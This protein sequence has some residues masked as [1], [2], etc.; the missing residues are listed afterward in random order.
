LQSEELGP[1]DSDSECGDILHKTPSRPEMS[2]EAPIPVHVGS[3][4]SALDGLANEGGP[5]PSTLS[6]RRSNP[7]GSRKGVD[8]ILEEENQ[9]LP[10]MKK[11]KRAQYEHHFML[12][13]TYRT[14]S[15]GRKSMEAK[16]R[17]LRPR[18]G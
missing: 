18:K 11:R 2:E 8:P 4:K 13:P 9:S 6:N 17:V 16:K 14:R 10:F 3:Q 1:P 12:K 5:G 7:E 15:A